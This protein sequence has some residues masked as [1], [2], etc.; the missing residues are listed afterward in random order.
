MTNYDQT[1]DYM[2]AMELDKKTGKPMPKTATKLTGSFY[3]LAAE[4]KPTVVDDGVEDGDDLLIVDTGE[5]HIF[6]KGTWYLQ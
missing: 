3:R 2:Q 1:D 5:V 6:Y 4:P